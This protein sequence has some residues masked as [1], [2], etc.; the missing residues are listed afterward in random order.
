MQCPC[1]EST[2]NQVH[3][4]KTMAKAMQWTKGTPADLPIK[5]DQDLCPACGRLEAMVLDVHGNRID[6]PQQ[7]VDLFSLS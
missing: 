4:V 3:E 6:V 1:G 2:I 7:A 5:V